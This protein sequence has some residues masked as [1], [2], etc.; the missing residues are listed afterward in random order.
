ME[1]IALLNGHILR[2]NLPLQLIVVLLEKIEE[3]LIEPGISIFD[4]P[5]GEDHEAGNGVEGEELAPIP[6]ESGEETLVEP[7]DIVGF[8]VL[9]SEE[10]RVGVLQ[11]VHFLQAS[12]RHLSQLDHLVVARAEGVAGVGVGVSAFV[13]G[14]IDIREED[15]HELPLLFEKSHD[16][17]VDFGVLDPQ[18][19]QA[20]HEEVVSSPHQLD[21]IP[22]TVLEGTPHHFLNLL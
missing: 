14:E 21:D 22:R 9:A 16:G 15:H 20:P 6:W 17:L 18:F 5:D 10:G 4:D 7:F 11:L 2:L 1:I 8:E 12:C 13:V 3:S 19:E